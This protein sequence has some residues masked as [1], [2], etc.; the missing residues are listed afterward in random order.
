MYRI[1]YTGAFKK[2]LTKLKKRSATDFETLRNLIKQ[3]AIK[4]AGGIPKKHRPHKLKGKFALHYE[5]HVLSDLLLI[6]MEKPEDKIIILVRTGT[7][8]DLF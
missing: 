3:L 4:G 2:D 8:S 6:W 5:C 1:K 7:H